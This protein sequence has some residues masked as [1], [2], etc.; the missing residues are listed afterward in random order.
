LNRRGRRNFYCFF[1]L[2]SKYLFIEYYCNMG[3]ENNS[4]NFKALQMIHLFQFCNL[5]FHENYL[6]NIIIHFSN[7]LAPTF[8]K[9]FL[10]LSILV[11]FMLSKKSSRD[12]NL[13]LFRTRNRKK[14]L[15]INNNLQIKRQ[16]FVRRVEIRSNYLWRKYFIVTAFEIESLHRHISP[17]FF[18]LSKVLT[19]SKFVNMPL[20]FIFFFLLF[21]L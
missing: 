20:V 15:E 7:L 8:L 16:P 13:W 17:T 1:S 14:Q 6:L 5:S 10:L 12:I 19:R 2:S 21:F 18:F 9:F 4:C 11:R 3:S